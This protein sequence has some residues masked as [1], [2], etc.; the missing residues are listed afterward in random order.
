MN[1]ENNNLDAHIEAIL[2]V[3]GE[4]MPVSGLV[5]ILNAS[6]KAIEEA[7]VSLSE[8]LSERGIRLVRKDKS[9]M[10][11]SSP[12]SSEFARLLLEDE[13]DS[14][15][16]KVG[17]ET[18]AIVV[19][20]GPVSRPEIDYIRGVNSAFILRNLLI[21]G[22]VERIPNPNDSRSFLYKPSFKLLQYLGIGSI[23][24]LPEYGDFNKKMEEFVEESENR[25][26]D[27]NEGEGGQ[28]GEQEQENGSEQADENKNNNNDNEKIIDNDNC[29]S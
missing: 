19:Y 21:R 26:R 27:E 12:E 29:L 1:N 2:F 10:L 6:E 7:L 25:D 14:K 15:L 3:K 5:K 28:E 20:K 8:K 4:P 17:L 13:V 22:L 23:S 18:L 16:T 9:V 24:E 11:A